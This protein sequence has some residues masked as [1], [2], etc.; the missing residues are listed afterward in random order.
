MANLFVLALVLAPVCGTA[1]GLM[2]QETN[3]AVGQVLTMLNNIVSMVETEGQTD[4]QEHQSFVAWSEGEKASV[5]THIGSLQTEI[6]TTQ[7][8]LADLRSQKADLEVVV[9]K[10]TADLTAETSQ[11]NQATERR[12][13]E[14][15]D[16]ITEQQNFANAMSACEQAVKLL[17]AHYGDGTAQ[18]AQKP[19]FLS[20]ISK[21]VGAVRDA[22]KQ[23]KASS[24]Q[25]KVSAF[26]QRVS[27][28]SSDTYQDSSGEAGSIV[29]QVHELAET[30]GEDKQSAVE[31]E[32]GLQRAY[33]TLHTQKSALIATLTEERDSQ[34]SQLNEVNQNVAEN[35]GKLQMATE[36]LAD[37]Q[38]YAKNL[39]AQLNA[40]NVGYA[41]RKKDREAELAAVN[42]AVGVLERVSLLQWSASHYT[43]KA[44]KAGSSA[45]GAQHANSLQ[46]LNAQLANFGKGKAW[47][48]RIARRAKFHGTVI[49]NL[50]GAGPKCG[51]NCAKVAALLRQKA[52][53]LH[54]STLASAAATALG[55][56]QLR[57]VIQRLDGLIANLDQEQQTEKDHKTWCETEMSR[58]KQTRDGH[59]Y[60]VDTITQHINSLTELIG[61]KTTEFGGNRGDYGDENGNFADQT[62]V[63]DTDHREYEEDI[64]DAQD[65]I[66]AM[67]EAIAILAKFYASRAKEAA[68][69]QVKTGQKTNPDSGSQ[70]VGLMSETRTEFE[71]AAV[72]LKS[73]E[74]QEADAYVETRANHMQ[75][76]SVLNQEGTVLT[77][78]KQTASQT[79]SSNTEDLKTNKGEIVAANDYIRRLGLSC[80]P[81]IENFENRQK[82]RGEEKTAIQDAIKVLQEV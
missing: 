53:V 6:Q 60:A 19:E 31:Q 22:V 82:L 64:Q 44:V 49:K 29:D 5:A 11:L 36:L 54:S 21:T 76:E 3:P 67:N 74:Q 62:Q 10:V 24:K 42:E 20:L 35:E 8:V 37:R 72:D 79:L 77:V 7:A 16:F 1:T 40:A 38:S 47:A 45:G 33:D 66:A 43:S 61:M 32:E 51:G 52:A 23:I 18:E 69:V 34:Q 57:D 70:V 65:A 81:L 12:G 13:Q 78:E 27:G 71:H 50:R 56:E 68:L 4:E 17:A 59:E 41:A 14:N 25:A 55:N 73:R 58:T 15:A 80:N 30:F 46:I 9:A 48:A 39:V 63:R 75:T 2:R 26:L 28:P